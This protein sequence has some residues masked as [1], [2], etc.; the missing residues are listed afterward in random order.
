MNKSF[1]A[2]EWEEKTQTE[3]APHECPDTK[4]F[5]VF[6]EMSELRR[7]IK[8]EHLNKWSPKHRYVHANVVDVQIPK[9]MSQFEELKGVTIDGGKGFLASRLWRAVE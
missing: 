6:V 4:C 3:E 7:H 8:H 1:R 2:P 9:E 5:C